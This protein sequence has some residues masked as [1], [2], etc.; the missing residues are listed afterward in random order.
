MDLNHVGALH[1]ATPKT[2]QNLWQ[3]V[4]ANGSISINVAPGIVPMEFPF[5]FGT[6]TLPPGGYVR[7][8][9]HDRNEELI[10]V[11]SGEGTA[12]LDGVEHR[13]EPGMTIFL[14]RNRRHKFT[15]TG[16]TELHWVW[17]IVPNGL[18]TFFETIG[19]PRGPGEAAPIP[20]PRP[21]NVLSIERNSVFGAA[22]PD[23]QA[24]P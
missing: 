14:G 1:V 12:V 21:D 16:L 17:L 15:N 8:H 22:I 4:P 2:V 5:G 18:E 9:T 23:G 11:I 3:P 24:K 13:M 10:H 6:Q 7:E 20:F 19:R